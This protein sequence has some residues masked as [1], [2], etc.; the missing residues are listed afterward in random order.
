MVISPATRRAQAALAY[1]TLAALSFFC[2]F[3]FVWMLDT[4]LKPLREVQSLHPQLWIL[5]PT[6]DSFRRVL[7]QTSFPVYFR[8]S[9]IVAGAVTLLTLIVSVFA[10]Y[11]LSRWPHATLSRTVGAALLLSQMIPGV[12]VLVPLYLLMRQLG[13]LSSYAGLIVVYLS[14]T[15]PLCVFMLKGFFDAVPA[16]L[17]QAA[18]LDGCSRVGYIYRIL[19][20]LSGPGVLA[21]AAFAFVNAWNEFMFGYV[22]INDDA[23]RTLTPGIMMFKSAHVTDWGGLMAASVLAVVPVA[24][25]FLYLQRFLIEG[26]AAGAVKG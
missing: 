4:A 8:N 23:H 26:L 1:A 21:A 2:L 18:E 25:C 15:V 12:L 13:L 24:L 20:P 16:E 6:L 17:E 14:F 9:L 7:F 5:H 22:F 19:L 10:A 11:V 3:P